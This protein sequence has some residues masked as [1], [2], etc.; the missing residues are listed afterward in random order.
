MKFNWNLMKHHKKISS[1]LDLKGLLIDNH[2]FDI[3]E[4]IMSKL[5]SE[6]V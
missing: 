2:D 1:R 6:P 3:H 5:S 4:A